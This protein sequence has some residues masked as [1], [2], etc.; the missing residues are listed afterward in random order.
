MCQMSEIQI[1]SFLQE[2]NAGD[3]GNAL[4]ELMRK[5]LSATVFKAMGKLKPRHR[6]I[7][8][9]RCLEQMPYSEIASIIQR[10][11]IDEETT[12]FAGLL[13]QFGESL[14]QL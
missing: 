10:M 7:L 3:H 8:I 5:E 1:D 9:L 13:Q 11:N 4:Q 14:G 12:R 2:C 6:N